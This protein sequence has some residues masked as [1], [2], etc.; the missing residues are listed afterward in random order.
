[1]K[2]KTNLDGKSL[3]FGALIHDIGKSCIPD[4]VLNKKGPHNNEEWIVMR[5][6][7]EIGSSILKKALEHSSKSSDETIDFKVVN[8]IIRYHHELINGRGYPHEL[9]QSRIPIEAKIVSIAD[10]FDACVTNRSYQIKRPW[11]EVLKNDIRGKNRNRYCQKL[12]DVLNTAAKP[13]IESKSAN[14]FS[15]KLTQK[16]QGIRDKHPFINPEIFHETL[17][18]FNKCKEK[19]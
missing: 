14:E 8:N 17:F 13:L 5:R 3:Y 19:P 12:V 6:H 9:P 15:T 16:I 4:S 18:P 7:P 11:S 2:N 10:S 1:M